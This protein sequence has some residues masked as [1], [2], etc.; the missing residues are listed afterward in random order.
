M[1]VNYN[2]G[3]VT[4]GLVLCVDAANSKSYPGTG[5]TWNDISSSAL[6]CDLNPSPTYNSDGY[7]VFDGTNDQVYVTGLPAMTSY[8]V[9]SVH[10][11]TGE[12]LV[13]ATGYSTI[14]GSGGSNRLLVTSSNLL[15]QMGGGNHFASGSVVTDN[16]W[17]HVA[18]TYDSATTT[19]TWYVNGVPKGTLVAAT[20]MNT[21]QYIGSYN[22]NNYRWNGRIA[23][24]VVYNR[25]LAQAEV[26]Q[27]FNA[28][29][30][31]YGI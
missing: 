12:S 17:F 9:E 28:I 5:T 20:T 21:T 14:F 1:G 16:I 13:G 10:Y 24:T 25:C 6:N 3:I 22:S 23:R 4:D 26:K 30:G 7:F 27:N 31:R 11:R 18:W 19:A 15:A 2:P 8:S 29:R